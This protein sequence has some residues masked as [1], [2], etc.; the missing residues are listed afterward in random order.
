[1][2]FAHNALRPKPRGSALLLVTVIS[3]VLAVLCTSLIVVTNGENLAAETLERFTVTDALAEA[4]LENGLRAI[5]RATANYQPV[6]AAGALIIAGRTVNYTI[7]P[8]GAQRLSAEDDGF[9]IIT[10]AYH[11]QSSVQ[12]I[13]K[14]R[15]TT[16]ILHRVVDVQQQPIF[17]YLSFYGKGD[18]EILPGPNATFTGRVHCNNDIY[19]GSGATL[20]LDSRYVRAAG[21]MHRRRKDDNSN[22][23]GTV[24]IK[25]KTS[26][27]YV[28]MESKAQMSALGMPSAHGFDSRFGG[29]DINGDGDWNDA[30]ERGSFNAEAPM[31]W[32]GVVDV[33]ATGAQA[34]SSP[35]VQTIKPF[36]AQHGGSYEYDAGTQE[37]VS[38]PLGTGTHEKGSF[39]SW[40][41]LTIKNDKAYDA[42]GNDITASLPAGTISSTSM[43][44]GRE[45]KA[46]TQTQVDVAKL[47]SSGKFPANGLLYAYRTDATSAQPN[48]IRLVNGSTLAAPLTVVSPNPVYVKGDY[49]TVNKKGAAIMSDAVN[50]LS[51]AWANTK[52]AGALPAASDTKYNFAM[53]SGNYE[54]TLGRYNGGFEN[55]PR[56]HENWTG[57][58]CYIRGSFINLWNS[59]YAKNTW[60]YGSDRYT[61]PNRNWNFDTDFLDVNKLPPFTPNVV[62]SVRVVWWKTLRR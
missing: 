31:R 40:A 27:A 56:F 60:V 18:L 42:A 22:S 62:G 4:G 20:Q 23:T 11:I 53:I 58:E 43:Y 45:R 25:N 13:E 6:P 49:N 1:M 37:Y 34:M 59:D 33:A 28:S 46:V 55:F 57:K 48:G 3:G 2:S 35:E 38:V 52:A 8:V 14:G 16:S 29:Y 9:Q 10:Q 32:G 54:T 5:T 7:N 26:G 36:A 44:D 47:N 50:L 30:G 15:E 12:S 41:S 51:N 21:M 17:Q 61:A 24:S 39:H 19:I